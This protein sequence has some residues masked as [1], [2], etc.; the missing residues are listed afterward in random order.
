VALTRSLP[1]GAERGVAKPL[2]LRVAHYDPLSPLSADVRHKQRKPKL[3]HEAVREAG[4]PVE[5]PQLDHIT[6]KK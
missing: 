5:E 6:V 1:S 4:T 2:D 3:T